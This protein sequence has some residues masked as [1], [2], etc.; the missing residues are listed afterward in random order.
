MKLRKLSN[1]I[2]L[3][4]MSLLGMACISVILAFALAQERRDGLLETQQAGELLN[5][6]LRAN[7]ALTDITEGYAYTRQKQYLETHQQTIERF[8]G[9]EPILAQLL[10]YNLAGDERT[11]LEQARERSA[12]LTAMEDA[13]F[14]FA[15]GGDINMALD[16][17]YGTRYREH[18]IALNSLIGDISLSM[19]NRMQDIR[20]TLD[21]KVQRAMATALLAMGLNLLL[22]LFTLFYLYKR[23]VLDP[24]ESLTRKTHRLAQGEHSLDFSHAEDNEMGDLSRALQDYQAT[25]A[26]LENQ[27][28]KLQST[29]TWYRHIIEASPDPMVVVDDGGIILMANPRMHET[30]GYPPG[31]LLGL[32][33]D[34]LVPQRFRS[35]HAMLREA[36]LHSGGTIA[37]GSRA[38][39]YIGLTRSGHELPLEMSMTRMPY[40]DGRGICLCAVLRDIS[41]R[42]AYERT[43]ADQ[44]NFKR[45]LLNTLPYPVFFKD[46]QGRYLGCNQAFLEA[47]AMREE[48][49]LGKTVHD[50]VKLPVD[51]RLFF[52]AQN[53]ALLQQGGTLTVE[54]EIPLADGQLHPIIYT[55]ASF[56]GSEQGISGLVGTLIDIGAQKESERV[57]AEAR[58]LAEEAARMKS[59]FLAN[60]SHEIRTPMNVIIGM[61]HLALQSDLAP[62][63]RNYIEKVHG[64]AQGLLGIINDILDFSKIEAGKLAFEQAHFQLDDVMH[65]LADLSVIDAQDKDLELLFDIATDVPTALVGD[66]LRLG[67]VL[68]NLLSNA[69]KFTE[70]G[71][72][73]VSIRVEDAGEQDVGLRFEVSDTGIGIGEADRLRLFQAFTQADSS[74]SRRHGGTGLGLTISKRLVEM[75]NG[76]IGVE[77]GPGAGSTFWFSARF[78][79]QHGQRELPM[80]D[81]DVQGMRILVVDDNA[82]ARQIFTAMLGALGFDVATLSRGEEAVDELLR[83]QQQGRP[84]RLVIMDWLMP[85]MG[86]VEAVR[87]IRAS[88]VAETPL[89]V[90][91]TAY[92]R[93]ELMA[94]LGDL[95][96]EAI[97]IKPVTPSILLKTLLNAFGKQVARQP[98]RNLPA[99]E[100]RQAREEL[101]GTRLLLVEDNPLNQEM[102]VDILAQAGIHVEVAEHGAQALE[103][104]LCSDYDGVLMDCQMPVMDGFEAT[105]RIRQ[106]LG[107]LDLP[108][109]AMT[110]NA[111]AGDKE[112]CLAAG[113]NAHI[114]KPIDVQRLFITL[115]QWIAPRQARPPEDAVAAEPSADASA[116]PAI[117]GLPQQAQA[118]ERLA[119]DAPLLRRLIRRFGETQA[120]S[121][122]R[123][124]QALASEDRASAARIAHTLKGLAATIGATALA[125]QAAALE[126]Q[127]R[128]ERHD[129]APSAL[130]ALGQTLGQ[131]LEQIHRALP[132]ATDEAPSGQAVHDPERL[133]GQLEQLA[134]LLREDDAAAIRVVPDIVEQLGLMQRMVA[135]D[136][137]NEL[138]TRY[139][140]EEALAL[141]EELAGEMTGNRDPRVAAGQPHRQG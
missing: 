60:M 141:V 52:Q 47:F 50:L 111:M 53:Q 78:G 136:E 45:V 64:A 113:M 24:L 100:Y 68:L 33:A 69:I 125:E 92:S 34:L 2:S 18:K 110:A 137:L 63:Q 30:F 9:R 13:V 32:G 118:L 140:F 10:R 25:M 80:C 132:P 105:R 62:G 103:M 89:F 88:E 139:A 21:G 41:Q 40:L 19:Q 75:M 85:G 72:V 106:Q 138:V 31:E 98:Q 29:E 17:I 5:R 133:L 49:L 124:R 112:S 4:M 117:P 28:R 54:T 101:R 27:R 126:H 22:V 131:L 93:D 119:G 65:N 8:G 109:L 115:R 12:R 107:L 73:K 37:V 102:A 128:H 91:A 76:E 43:I 127:L 86:G 74:T 20:R 36:F 122:E 44:L 58:R 90:M 108:V 114:A 1:L 120:D 23:K 94:S 35:R 123:I 81:E 14:A 79:L 51:K 95:P 87:H 67:Q 61:S 3:L 130:A 55:L 99:S 15:R 82:S 42:M 11:L 26:E 116:L 121:V 135:A 66:Q 48:D 104:L 77:S 70:R 38:G 56:T 59:D 134:R 39:S 97:L 7:E 71:E 83:A 57:I 6:F 16:A 84:Y 46:A 96:I 129:P